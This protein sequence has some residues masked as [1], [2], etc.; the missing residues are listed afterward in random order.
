MLLIFVDQISERLI[1]TF[2]FIFKDRSITYQV[3]NDWLFFCNQEDVKFVYSEKFS[4][5]YLQIK[6]STLLFDEAIFSYSINNYI[7]TDNSLDV[8]E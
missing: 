4:E 6:P 8:F 7:Y 1:Y 2:D 3:T 5:D